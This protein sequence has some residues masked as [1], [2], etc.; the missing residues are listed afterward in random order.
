VRWHLKVLADVSSWTRP[1][2]PRVLGQR[3]LRG[4]LA[5]ARAGRQGAMP[6]MNSGVI[7]NDPR[8]IAAFRSALSHPGDHRP[9]SWWRPGTRGALGTRA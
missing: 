7:L 2:P 3:R 4:P 6:G 9:V 5:G 8:V 1:S